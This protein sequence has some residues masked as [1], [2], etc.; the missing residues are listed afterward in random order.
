MGTTQN[1]RTWW[2]LLEPSGA[3]RPRP[4][5]TRSTRLLVRGPVSPIDPLTGPRLALA[6]RV[7]TMD[8]RDSVRSDAVVYV[9][10]GCIVDVRERGQSAPD[11]FE[12]TAVLQTGGTIFP[13]L[14]ELHNHL[15][16]NALPLWAPVPKAFDNRDQWADYR[17]YRRLVSGPM[18]VIGKTPQ[19]LPA[20]VRYVECKCLLAGVTTSQGIRL[21][22]NSGVSRYYR[23][24]VRNVEQTREAALPEAQTR[25]QDV[26][27]RDA[28]AFKQELVLSQGRRC[29][30]L[31]LSEGLTQPSQPD[32]PARRH[33][34]ALEVA[35]N[36]WALTDALAGIHAAGLLPADFDR[37][38]EKGSSI[39]WSPLSN[40]LLYGQTARVEA[41]RRAGVKIGLGGD[42]SPSGSKNLLAELKVAWLYSQRFLDGVFSARD[43]VAMATRTAAQILKW[44]AVLGSVEAGKRA[45]LLVVDGAAGDPHDSLVRARETSVRLVVINGVPRYGTRELMDP[46]GGGDQTVRVG[47][48][49][50]R[51]FLRQE[52]VPGEVAG[53][54]LATARSVLSGAFRDIQK[55]ARELESRPDT[56]PARRGA[57]PVDAPEP[58]VWSLALDETRDTGVELRPRLPYSGPRDFTGPEAF[59]RRAARAAASA[60][61]SEILRPIALDPLTVVDDGDFL[62]QI[63]GQPNVP[64]AVRD[65]LR[66]FY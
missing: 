30:L 61:L 15:S 35:P 43:L 66:E 49:T 29:Y 27:A 44:D 58:V 39:V 37:L 9:E 59:S 2:P 53:L 21:S 16:Y 6:G 40:L 7:V 20:L 17:D 32:S 26:D 4:G 1:A 23:G 5:R 8:A 64:E 12:T 48:E 38:A 55:L 62:D 19:L 57:V 41:A 14:I 22:S 31:H 50:R 24:I 34:L 11:G 45:D 18:A 33:F 28:R 65:G 56:R 25:I 54:P 51:L 52:T 36:D 46:L 42:W 3:G 63:A 60:K 13:G 10:K 47:G